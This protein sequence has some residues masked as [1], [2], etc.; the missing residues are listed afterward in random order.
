EVVR[1]VHRAHSATSQQGI[2]SIAFRERRADHDAGESSG[3]VLASPSGLEMSRTSVHARNQAGEIPHVHL[4][5]LLV[6]GRGPLLEVV[7]DVAQRRPVATQAVEQETAIADL[8][9][10]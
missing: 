9:E 5:R 8:L 7:L 10:I 6:G 2:D 1:A 3:L 4:E